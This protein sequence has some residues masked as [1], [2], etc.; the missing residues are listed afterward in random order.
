MRTSS[1]NANSTN[2]DQQANNLLNLL[3]SQQG[4]QNFSNNNQ[5]SK[6]SYGS[7]GRQNDRPRNRS[8]SPGR[9]RNNDM[10]R[11]S[12][13]PQRSRDRGSPEVGERNLPGTPHYRPTNI[14][15]DEGLP[16]GCIRAS[17]R[18]LFIGGV[19]PYMSKEEL[20]GV[21][22]PYA[23]VQSVT[24]NN[25]RKH[26]FVKVYSRLEA[27]AI[28]NKFEELNESGGLALRVRWGVGFGPR[29]CCDYS[30]GVSVVPIARLTDAD[31]RWTVHAEWGGT[32]G[33]PLVPGICIEE[34]DIEIGAGVSSKAISKRMPTN[35]A[36]NGPKSTNP[37]ERW[38]RGE[39][40]SDSGNANH[41]PLG[42]RQSHQ[43]PSQTQPPAPNFMGGNNNP[44]GMLLQNFSQ[45]PGAGNQQQ[46]LQQQQQQ[47]QPQMTQQ[48]ALQALQNL[49]A[50]QGM[51]GMNPQMASFF[52]QQNQHPPN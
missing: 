12:R 30:T 37:Q 2:S 39:R 20:A 32:G 50:L 38:G 48:Q 40:G 29:D 27:E 25:E 24:I 17:S 4:N 47:Q 43:P 16:S 3:G 21:L 22:R 44:L 23:E 6:D 33:K 19:P 10:R 7:Y 51:M 36:K 14:S 46:P 49:Q 41:T 52:Q 42:S 34:P 9:R 31:K 35:S 18:T 26:A 45:F 15:Y 5:P 1:A 13:S 11:R 8:R 28:K